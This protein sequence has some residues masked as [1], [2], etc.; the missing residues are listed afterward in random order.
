MFKRGITLKQMRALNADRS[1][2]GCA[3]EHAKHLVFLFENFTST[4]FRTVISFIE[5]LRTAQP[6]LHATLVFLEDQPPFSKVKGSEELQPRHEEF[7]LDFVYAFSKK[8]FGFGKA[9]K[10]TDLNDLLSQQFDLLISPEDEL[11]E[12]T[13]NIHVRLPSAF[14]VGPSNDF[15]EEF[16][17]FCLQETPHQELGAFLNNLRLNLHQFFGK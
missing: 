8:D 17:D 2:K 12:W 11:N 6:N 4:K 1:I 7:L 15:Q 14:K 3:V 10:N 5:N 13:K 16:S 9:I